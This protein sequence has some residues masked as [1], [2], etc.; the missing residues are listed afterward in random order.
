MILFQFFLAL[1]ETSDR[2]DDVDSSVNRW[3]VRGSWAAMIHGVA[4][5]ALAVTVPFLA[6]AV[7]EQSRAPPG[8]FKMSG[9]PGFPS[10]HILAR[11]GFLELVCLR[12][13]D[14]APFQAMR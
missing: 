11:F 3:V 14:T 12:L 10:W 8:Y 2:Q 1:L 13:I 9:P 7:Q 5:F 6:G 4:L